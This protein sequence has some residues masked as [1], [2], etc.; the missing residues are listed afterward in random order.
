MEKY[1]SECW[2]YTGNKEEDDKHA[3]VMGEMIERA[4]SNFKYKGI[5]TRESEK[6]TMYINGIA[7]PASDFIFVNHI[8]KPD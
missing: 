5:Y 3:R 4:D 7:R 1:Y 8:K 2:L 6:S